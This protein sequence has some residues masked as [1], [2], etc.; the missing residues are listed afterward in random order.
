MRLL[1]AGSAAALTGQARPLAAISAPRPAKQ[2]APAASPRMRAEIEKQ[3]QYVADAL[4][5]IREY[6]LPPG[7]DLAFVF[8]PLRPPRRK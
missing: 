5:A 4:K 2:P 7:S 3:K 6:E 1:A 8:R